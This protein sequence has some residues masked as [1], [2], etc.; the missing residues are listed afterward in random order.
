[1]AVTKKH[2]LA[3]ETKKSLMTVART[4]LKSKEYRGQTAE[5]WGVK[6]NRENSKFKKTVKEREKE[7]ES[8][9]R[10]IVILLLKKAQ[11]NMFTYWSQRMWSGGEMVTDKSK[12]S[13]DVKEDT[14]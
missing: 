9:N 11:L 8:W 5:D 14:V 1:M 13:E 2:P 3:L 12:A 10:V 6:G 4:V 7:K